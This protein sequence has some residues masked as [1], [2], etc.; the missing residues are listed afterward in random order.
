MNEA[1]PLPRAERVAAIRRQVMYRAAARCENPDCERETHALE[2][3]H[4]HGGPDRQ[5]LEAVETCWGL[6]VACHRAR[7]ANRPSAAI[8]NDRFRRHC[9][10]YGYAFVPHIEHALLPP[11]GR[12][13]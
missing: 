12:V 9:E 2:M 6:C 8:W 4:W 7:Q 5:R 1:L 10:R 11:G 3:D 13:E